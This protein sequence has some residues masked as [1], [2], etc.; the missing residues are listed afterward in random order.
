MDELF[1]LVIARP[2][3][4]TDAATLPLERR[5]PLQNELQKVV[6]L[7]P[8]PVWER[9]EFPALTFL[10][11]NLAWIEQVFDPHSP[12]VEAALVVQ[13]ANFARDAEKTIRA[14]KAP[15]SIA[16]V[17]KL[18]QPFQGN[19]ATR[20]TLGDKLCDLFVALL[21]ARANGPTRVDQLIRLKMKI[22]GKPF[23]PA[24][25]L[26][27]FLKG[28]RPSLDRIAAI[29]RQ[30]ATI[31]G[32]LS[33]PAGYSNESEILTALSRS[34][35]LPPKIF[36]RLEKPVHAVGIADRS[37]S[38]SMSCAMSSVRLRALRTSCAARLAAIRRSMRSR[39]SAKPSSSPPRRPPPSKK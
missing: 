13:V 25:D 17:T 4:V 34:L 31:T 18:A 16:A 3:E 21:I 30:L 8:R 35:L 33:Q 7:Y 39:T 28:D 29:L 1:R 23:T 6:T 5:T 32:A 2:A 12:A 10:S 19:A 9:L 14:A 27:D 26:V 38:S 24:S 15:L 22:G 37:W 36:G 11:N 20:T